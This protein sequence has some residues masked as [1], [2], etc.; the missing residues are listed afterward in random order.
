MGIVLRRNWN[1]AKVRGRGAGDCQ[2]P[3]ASAASRPWCP[4][5]AARGA[6]AG[7]LQWLRRPPFGVWGGAA[8]TGL[9]SGWQQTSAEHT[10]TPQCWAGMTHL[11][12]ATRRP[13]GGGPAAHG[14]KCGRRPRRPA[15]AGRVA[16]APWVWRRGGKLAVGRHHPGCR[17]VAAPRG[18]RE[19]AVAPWMRRCGGHLPDGRHAPGCGVVVVGGAPRVPGGWPFPSGCRGVVGIWPRAV[20]SPAAVELRPSRPGCGCVVGTC[21]QAITFPAAVL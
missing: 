10:W 8:R 5:P 18:C 21:R 19:V 6:V 17:V 12:A 11:G 4:P 1:A 15:G 20:T 9:L 13:P 7:R 2:S 14:L 3:A 16:V